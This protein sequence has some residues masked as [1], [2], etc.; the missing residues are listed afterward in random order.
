MN[1]ERYRDHVAV[2]LEADEMIHRLALKKLTNSNF[3]MIIP[4]S[5]LYKDGKARLLY[6]TEGIRSFSIYIDQINP[7]KIIDILRDF[8]R[9]LNIVEADVFI[10]REMIALDINDIYFDLNSGRLKVFITPIIYKD[11]ETKSREWNKKL[12]KLLYEASKRVIDSYTSSQNT[13]LLEKMHELVNTDASDYSTKYSLLERFVEELKNESSLCAELDSYIDDNQ[14][15]EIRYKGVMGEFSFYAMKD[16]FLI[17][18]E[19]GL[20]A[21]IK[22]NSAVSRRHCVIER[23]DGKAY[24]FDLGSLNHT[25]V[26]GDKLQGNEKVLI[27]NHDILRI[28]D[29][30][31]EIIF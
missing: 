14:I 10:N 16:Y 12:F 19:D 1:I 31:F 23:A 13:P 6:P 3:E 21:C 9:V 7:D 11:Q 28:A 20:D 15:M 4:V 22:N 30:D 29:M 2:S 25:Y 24:V 8:G 27:R 5:V 26:N 17:G 18:K